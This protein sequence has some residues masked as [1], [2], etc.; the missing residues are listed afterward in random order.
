MSVLDYFRGLFG[1]KRRD[2]PGTSGLGDR[3]SYR[4]QFRNPIWEYD[5]DDD[6][7]DDFRHPRTGIR[8]HIF[9]DPFEMT[10]YFE[11]EMENMLKNFGFGNDFH[12]F[13]NG[14]IGA[15]PPAEEKE[16]NASTLRD[17]M[18]KSASDSSVLTPEQK[19]DTDL[20]GKLTKDDFS[21][22]W[23]E[24]I[25]DPPAPRSFNFGKFVKK[26]FVRR[27]DGI[28]EQ[29]QVIRDSEGNQE[30]IVT[31]EIGD[32]KYVVTTKT[33]K[34]GVETKSEDL[35]NMDESDLQDFN[36]KWTRSIENKTDGRDSGL[37]RFPWARFFGPEPKL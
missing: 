36:K 13:S 26:E 20:D 24:R 15:L 4:D 37:N 18:L 23:Q 12:F 2:E 30:T 11:S 22:M 34:Y 31:R 1:A 3:Y 7:M 9:S 32:Q 8:F 35:I 28:L 27:P 25:E 14:I 10:R 29:K 21:K 5:E 6:D 17:R 16:S 19:V 33:D